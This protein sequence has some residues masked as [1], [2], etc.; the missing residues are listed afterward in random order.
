MLGIHTHT[1]SVHASCL[2]VA[3][4]RESLLRLVMYTLQSWDGCMVSVY[5]SLSLGIKSSHQR[6]RPVDRG[7]EKHPISIKKNLSLF[8]I[9]RRTF[10]RYISLIVGL[11]LRVC[12]YCKRARTVESHTLT[13]SSKR[14]CSVAQSAD[15]SEEKERETRNNINGLCIGQ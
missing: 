10:P 11:L 14:M 1:L 3:S 5:I 6:H 8:E 12:N 2:S 15:L 4:F 9:S 7:E 13:K